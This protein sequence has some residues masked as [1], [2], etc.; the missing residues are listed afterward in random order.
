M[1]P[2]VRTLSAEFVRTWTPAGGATETSG[3]HLY[4]DA[5]GRV[6]VDVRQPLHQLMQVDG[7]HLRILYPETGKAYDIV[8]GSPQVLPFFQALLAMA[9]ESFGLA[10]KGYSLLS[11][12]SRGDTLVTVWNPPLVTRKVF[13]QSVL[14]TLQGRLVSAEMLS[15]AG[16]SQVRYA[17]T[18]ATKLGGL[19]FAERTETRVY[20]GNGRGLEQVQF[21]AFELNRPLPGWVSSFRLPANAE[22][23]SIP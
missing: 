9:D 1:A 18:K 21:S 3:G 20:I 23:R 15:P 16:K 2:G 4:Y 22:R 6:L 17:C 11:H 14:T 10:A 13:G 5:S 7:E 8:S 19:V 12:T